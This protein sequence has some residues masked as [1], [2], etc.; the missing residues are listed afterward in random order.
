MC[1]PLTIHLL[2]RITVDD[3]V[4]TNRHLSTIYA[5][6]PQSK[7]RFYGTQRLHYAAGTLGR[8]HFNGLNFLN[9]L[10]IFWV[11]ARVFAS[12]SPSLIDLLL[13]LGWCAKGVIP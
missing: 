8:D 6:I 1:M 11:N 4:V 12:S 10:A 9:C 2:N 3:H 5:G 7:R 13:T